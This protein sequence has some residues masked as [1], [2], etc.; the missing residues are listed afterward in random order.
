M[1]IRLHIK[2]R[3]MLKDASVEFVIKA[4]GMAFSDIKLVA[5]IGGTLVSLSPESSRVSLPDVAAVST[6]L[7]RMW[8]QCNAP[9][10]IHGTVIVSCPATVTQTLDILVE[11]PFEH[12]CK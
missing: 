12:K 2:A 4:S 11:D 1:P 5:D 6:T 9:G 3:G 7:V 8:L 10:H